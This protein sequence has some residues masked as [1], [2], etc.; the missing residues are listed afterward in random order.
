M[1]IGSYE[2][3]P[4]LIPTLATLCMMIIT[5]SAGRWQLNRV[6]EKEALQSL[7]R[8]TQQLPAVNLAQPI[9][10]ANSLRY[11]SLVAEGQF[12]PDKQIYIDNREHDGRS[13]YH[14]ITPLAIAGTGDIV[15]VNRGWVERGRNYSVAP[16][17]KVANGSVRVSGTGSL[18]SKK[19][20]ELSD[21]AIAGKVWQNLTFERVDAVL[22]LKVLPI[23]VLQQND[24]TNGLSPVAEQP[25]FKINMH[26][27][28]A[29]QWF[30]LTAT[31]LVI[32]V[33]V[34][35]KRKTA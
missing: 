11:R 13:G 34:N 27:G 18:S 21:Q 32:Y 31:L 9:A 25:D 1:Q 10:D 19:F 7:F 28:Y 8:Q 17:V 22:G 15:L 16:D 29:F 14:V 26:R 3:R 20:L 24:L 6:A 5:F 2:F 30:A 23:I 35:S 33:V 12:L 4:R